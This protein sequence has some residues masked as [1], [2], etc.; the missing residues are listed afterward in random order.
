MTINVDELRRYLIEEHNIQ[1]SKD[2]PVLG[3]FLGHDKILEQYAEYWNETVVAATESVS[4]AATDQLQTLIDAQKD[5]SEAL[6][7]DLAKLQN[8]QLERTMKSIDD[9][10]REHEQLIAKEDAKN[11]IRLRAVGFFLLLVAIVYIF[12]AD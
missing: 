4:K 6:K 9:R 10:L 3:L 12:T 2:D 5:W 7:Q 11:T 8:D 1:V